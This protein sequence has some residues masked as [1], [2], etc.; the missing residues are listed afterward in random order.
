MNFCANPWPR[1]NPEPPA[2]SRTPPSWLNEPTTHSVPCSSPKLPLDVER[3][4]G[5]HIFHIHPQTTYPHPPPKKT[6]CPVVN[7]PYWAYMQALLSSTDLRFTMPARRSTCLLWPGTAI[8]HAPRW[9]IALGYS[10][11]WWGIPSIRSACRGNPHLRIGRPSWFS[12]AYNLIR[13]GSEGTL[14]STRTSRRVL[15]FSEF[16]NFFELVKYEALGSSESKLLI[17][18]VRFFYDIDIPAP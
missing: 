5:R 7:C 16:H 2:L 12:K 13:I 8:R 6:R 1:Q 14:C 10:T 4:P 9:G 17:K 11:A 15:G 3:L 18:Q